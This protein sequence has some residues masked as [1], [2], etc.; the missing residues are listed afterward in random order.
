MAKHARS[1]LINAFRWFGVGAGLMMITLFGRVSADAVAPSSNVNSIFLTLGAIGT[2]T[3]II[4]MLVLFW[5][6]RGL[7]EGE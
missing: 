6:A 4:G 1:H 5:G 7:R 2:L 3:V